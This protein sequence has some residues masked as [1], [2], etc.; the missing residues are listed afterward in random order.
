LFAAF[1]AAA[2]ILY[3]DT[4]WDPRLGG[5]ALEKMIVNFAGSSP[6]YLLIRLTQTSRGIDD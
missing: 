3:Q 6:D 2:I 4:L 5:L 1:D